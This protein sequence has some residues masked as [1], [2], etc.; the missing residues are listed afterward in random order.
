MLKE[1][2][3]TLFVGYASANPA[4]PLQAASQSESGVTSSPG[5]QK[6][7]IFRI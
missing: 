4:D 6:I 1:E 2:D 5:E 7:I 3:G